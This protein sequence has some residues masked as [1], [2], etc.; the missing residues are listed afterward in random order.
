M[1][2]TAL[3][4]LV[5]GQAQVM[6]TDRTSLE[7]GAT[8]SPEA[9][10][11]LRQFLSLCAERHIV[12]V[13]FIPPYQQSMYEALV[14]P[15]DAYAAEAKTGLPEAVASALGAYGFPFFDFT[16]PRAVG[17]TENEFFDNQHTTDKASARMLVAMAQRSGA[18]RPVVN[19]SGLE[20]LLAQTPGDAMMTVLR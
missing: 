4:D 17:I 3:H 6:R 20:R 5:D 15:H 11:S 1:R 8:T 12:V 2:V 14:G 13:G 18:L 7:Y 16:D 10:A 19:L 9:L